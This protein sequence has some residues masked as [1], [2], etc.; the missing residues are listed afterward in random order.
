M[1]SS[2][3]I[4]IKTKSDNIQ[5]KIYNTSNYLITSKLAQLDYL[6]IKDCRYSH[7]AQIGN[8]IVDEFQFLIALPENS[9]YAIEKKFFAKKL[10]NNTIQQTTQFREYLKLQNVGKQ[11]G[12]SVA[13]IKINPFTHESSDKN[14]FVYDSIEI[15]IKFKQTIHLSDLQNT[16]REYPF[17]SEFIN[18]EHI[19]GLLSKSYDNKKNNFE[20]TLNELW[21][22]PNRKYLK[23]L[24]KSDGI[25]KV[26]ARNLIN[27][28]P[29]FE[30]KELKY[31]HLLHKGIE[32]P[33]MILSDDDGFLN[34][35]DEI[36]FL[37]HR[38][39]GDT[40]WYDNY[41][42]YSAFYLYYDD[43][44]QGLR[45]NNFPEALSTQILDKV[46]LKKHFEYDTVY[47]HGD[48]S[49]QWDIENIHRE[50]WFWFDINSENKKQFSFDFINYLT[51]TID[52]DV[53]ML[54][55]NWNKS[56]ISKHNFSVLLNK[57]TISSS[58]LDTGKI[59]KF[60]YKIPI[61]NAITGKNDLT[62]INKGN[63]S[64]NEKQIPDI[65]A[66][67]YIELSSKI[68]P[69]AIY[70]KSAFYSELLQENK[71]LILP[72]F[73]TK[74]VFILDKT[75]NLF[76]NLSGIE[77]TNI[78][79]GTKNQGSPKSSFIINDSIFSNEQYSLDIIILKSPDF[80]IEYKSFLELNNQ[81][82]DFLN[83]AN[84]GS[85][86]AVTYNSNKQIPQNIISKFQSLGSSSISQ[87]S[88]DD[89]WVFIRQVGNEGAIFENHSK[90][91]SANLSEFIK[92]NN[93]K[94]FVVEKNLLANNYYD[95]IA[96]D[97]SA[98]EE[99]IIQPVNTTF[100]RNEDNQADAIY[101]THSNFK[102][103]ADSLADYQ[104]SK[105]YKIKIIDIED[106]YK[107]F[108]Y[109][110][111]SAHAIKN[112]LRYTYKNWEKPAPQFL[113][114]IGDANWD[115]RNHLANSINVDYVPTY[116]WPVSDYWYTCLD[117]GIDYLHDMFVG[118][119]PVT[120]NSQVIYYLNKLKEYDN[121]PKMPWMKK[122]LSL[123]GGG[124]NGE[125][126]IF[127]ENMDGILYSHWIDTP[128]SGDTMVVAKKNDLIV[129]VAEA[130][131]IIQKIDNGAI[132]VNFYGHG[133]P[134]V[135]DMDGWHAD[136]LNNKGKYPFFTTI[137]CNTSAF[138][139]PRG[140]SR[141]EGYLLIPEKGFIGTGGS[142]NLGVDIPGM[143]IISNM[144]DNVTDTNI[145][146]RTF[147]EIV[148]NAKYNMLS[149]DS[150]TRAYAQQFILLGD[151]MATIRIPKTR[152]IFILDA[153]VKITNAYDGNI[154]IESDSSAKVYGYIYNNGFCERNNI[155]LKLIHN[156]QD[157]SDTSYKYYANL[158]TKDIFLFDSLNIL[159]KPGLHTL[160]LF[161]ILS[162]T[163][164][165]IYN[166]NFEVF[167]SGLLPVEPLSYWNVKADYPFFR[168]INPLINN[169]FEYQFII[170][171]INNQSEDTIYTS[172][173]NEINIEENYI[174]W[175]PNITLDS[176]KQYLV[177]ARYYQ[178]STSEESKW[179]KIPFYVSQS[180]KQEQTNIILE[181][182]FLNDFNLID[183]KLEK[184][185]DSVSLVFDDIKKQFQLISAR[186]NASTDR[187]CE[188]NYDNDMYIVTPSTSNAPVGINMI[189][190]SG[191]D[192]SYI[193]TKKYNTWDGENS[194]I[195]LVNYLNDSVSTNDWVLLSSCGA[196][197]RMF[198]HT[199]LNNPDAIGGFG[200]FKKA[201]KNYGSILVDE[202]PESTDIPNVSF[203]FAGRKDSP[204]GASIEKISLDGSRISIN[205]SLTIF[206]NN[207]IL[208]TP[209]I[210]SAK[211]WNSCKINA[212]FDSS[213]ISI[214]TSIYG[215]NKD[216]T[217]LEL[218]KLFNDSLS[219]GLGFLD[220]DKFPKQI[221]RVEIKRHIENS[222]VKIK[223]IEINFTPTPEI[224]IS[225]NKT[226]LK[227]DSVLR[228]EQS[229]LSY[230]LENLSTRTTAENIPVQISIQ[231]N[232][233]N[234]TIYFDTIPKLNPNLTILKDFNIQTIQLTEDNKIITTANKS[235]NFNELYIFN[236][237]TQ[238]NLTLKRDYTNPTIKIKANGVEIHDSSY[239]PKRPYFEIE[240]YDY[241]YEPIQS[242][243]EPIKVWINSVKRNSDNSEDYNLKIIN[244]YGLKA[245]L[246]FWSDTLYDFDNR[247]EVV[248][249]DA[250]GNTD[251]L[252]Y[253]IFTSINAFITNPKCEP[254]P[255]ND[256]A[257]ITFSYKASDNSGIAYVTIF[258]ITGK[259]VRTL[260]Q[261]LI[262]GK[263]EIY[264]DGFNESG[265]TLPS[266]IYLYMIETKNTYYCEP[267]VDKFMKVQ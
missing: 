211:H 65:F 227:P 204:Q 257:K 141:N 160:Q 74:D 33:L 187:F 166:G 260:T 140:I 233:L 168:F 81:V 30:R 97:L 71:K 126:E 266:G 69:M 176:N 23:L 66:I 21:Y 198:Y 191:I 161:C 181:N 243:I 152:D 61:K 245:I 91:S 75:L 28:D 38:A 15:N 131:E 135:F 110:N 222:K 147:G 48:F 11:R 94:S 146:Q 82:L 165:N 113:L 62:I 224:A 261:D 93:G 84:T 240:M 182:Q 262:I 189:V 55:L 32:V 212:E 132:W 51:D 100:L 192:G 213:K 134:D 247:I 102:T 125:K 121:A 250:A 215:I 142:T 36:F 163:I 236:N 13:I 92:H 8:I 2:Q 72:N 210:S 169:N 104:K 39:E 34:S 219:F 193:T 207:G 170:T 255:I 194:T 237:S 248:F 60:N 218:I 174:D 25:A 45:F 41:T 67:D 7:P 116:G 133:A 53:N 6:K 73:K 117:N 108:N 63:F 223:R 88:P 109:G 267:V 1:L 14:W 196:A 217:K 246:G 183:L 239:V 256:N 145:N 148:Q 139:E 124:I 253:H 258:D 101:I 10:L 103:G 252:E 47:F 242:T 50:G 234:E 188:I 105:G 185:N 249:R 143:Q 78:I 49:L 52:I 235:G 186:G 144:M 127:K 83:T 43:K 205:D 150:V 208:L 154:L 153:E 27:I 76:S 201:L 254:N 22:N 231:P 214:Q 155:Q 230:Y 42:D 226:F 107:E 232:G 123:T 130:N 87:V 216:D 199:G 209:I 40:T 164:F 138:A 157:K 122:F 129:G 80:K 44:S 64:S 265:C 206:K 106:I 85:I 57:D 167:K 3:T 156:Y 159:Y 111:K 119:I 54:S 112:F 89:A 70:G 197:W 115:C 99:V 17:F 238:K 200:S 137:S 264:W 220:A 19:P 9:D 18:K 95:I 228:G 79:V 179:L 149:Y 68:K 35:E 26:S 24:T 118:R 173:P 244:E 114:L 158:C 58:Y 20:K 98:L 120:Q 136:K 162:D 4:D 172:H 259:K 202:I 96:S 59:V 177:Y 178:K 203:V 56:S 225:S 5:I 77:G 175:V 90:N 151:P 46:R 190:I 251:T 229:I 184:A 12:I 221:I 128:F 37:S 16:N 241:S 31:L 86:I 180:V 263:N 195:N 29:Y 171:T